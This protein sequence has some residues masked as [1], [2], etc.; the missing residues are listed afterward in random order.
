MRGDCVCSLG[1][2]SVD[3]SFPPK[4]FRSFQNSFAFHMLRRRVR[5]RDPFNYFMVIKSVWDQAT[6]IA[7]FRPL[8]LRG[9][10]E[11]GHRCYWVKNLQAIRKVESLPVDSSHVYMAMNLTGLTVSCSNCG[12][13]WRYMSCANHH[14]YI[15]TWQEEEAL[16]KLIFKLRRRVDVGHLNAGRFWRYQQHGALHRDSRAWAV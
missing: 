7:F 9:F 5:P 13:D 3:V 10:H 11:A 8:S 6:L 14:L 12:L 2:S 1:G 4:R 15:L 16:L